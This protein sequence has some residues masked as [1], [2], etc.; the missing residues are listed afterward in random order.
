MGY[1]TGCHSIVDTGAAPHRSVAYRS[2]KLPF[3]LAGLSSPQRSQRGPSSAR[4]R[5][6]DMRG[7]LWN[8]E[9]ADHLSHR[10]VHKGMS[11]LTT[12]RT[13]LHPLPAQWK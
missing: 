2:S 11:D 5:T 3:L 1:R 10:G 12:F 6:M 9:G 13:A 7:F 8:A 4:I